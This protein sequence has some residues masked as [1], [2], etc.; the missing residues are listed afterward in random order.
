M[1]KPR[2][3]PPSIA[4]SDVAAIQVG[5]WGCC[6]GLGSTSMPSKL[7]CAPWKLRRSW[8]H[9]RRTISTAS[10]KRS[11]LSSGGTPKALNSE[12]AKP[13][14]ARVA[15]PGRGEASPGAPIDPAARQHV[16]QRHFLGEAQRMI[17]RRQRHRRAD[18]QAFGARGGQRAQH[19][20]R[21][22]GPERAE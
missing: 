17:E 12:W 19:G 1:E 11:E 2:L 18:A 15:E 14:P 8:V 10:R 21:G 9:A 13:R 20:P 7:K 22:E 4:V 5:G 6:R 16:E 3:P